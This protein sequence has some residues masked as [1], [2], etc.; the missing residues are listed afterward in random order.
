MSDLHF[1]L[2]WEIRKS[3]TNIKQAVFKSGSVFN[4]MQQRTLINRL[5]VSI[6][7]ILSKDSLLFEWNGNMGLSSS[8]LL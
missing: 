1:P 7:C 2:G 6:V 5:T 4:V 8:D 3:S